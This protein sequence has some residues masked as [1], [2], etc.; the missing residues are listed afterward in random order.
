MKL[1]KKQK[2]I[3]D[4]V[5]AGN[6]DG[7]NVDLDQILE[8][9]PYETTK[10]SLQFSLRALI[11]QGLLK[12]EDPEKRRDRRRAVIAATEMGES[13]TRG[14]PATSAT[15]L[16]PDIESINEYLEDLT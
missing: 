5:I 3:M 2:N 16:Y 6:T 4:V 10:A 15:H 13:L 14:L 9:L 11:L 7:S 1:T 8:R 12:K